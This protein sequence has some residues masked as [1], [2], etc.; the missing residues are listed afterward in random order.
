M[1]TIG[2]VALGVCWGKMTV[3]GYDRIGEQT[4]ETRTYRYRI[5]INTA[6]WYEFA[7]L[8]GIGPSYSK[9]IIEYRQRHGPFHSIDDL[10]R[11]KGIGAHRLERMRP[12][13]T[14][15]NDGVD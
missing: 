8:E 11:V 4:D 10:K 5:N 3:R 2:L 14:L 9:R 7:L 12:W 1:L 6:S 13:L 15:G